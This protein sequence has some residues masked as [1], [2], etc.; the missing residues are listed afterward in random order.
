M[1]KRRSRRS[2]LSSLIPWRKIYLELCFCSRPRPILRHFFCS[3]I[4]F[5]CLRTIE[6]T[7]IHLFFPLLLLHFSFLPRIALP[8]PTAP[9]RNATKNTCSDGCEGNANLA[10]IRFVCPWKDRRDTWPRYERVKCNTENGNRIECSAVGL[11]TLHGC[12]RNTID[13]CLKHF[14]FFVCGSPHNAMHLR[15]DRMLR[16]QHTKIL[17]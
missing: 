17:K 10:C 8:A 5:F 2:T 3:S 11:C 9:K 13:F 6:S 12:A 15:C 1:A 4:W 14:M 7:F 16:F